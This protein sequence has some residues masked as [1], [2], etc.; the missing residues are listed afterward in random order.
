M[1]C[2]GAYAAQAIAL[3]LAPDR[4][5]PLNLEISTLRPAVDTPCRL[6]EVSTR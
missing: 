4:G 6:D 3:P 2:G 1:G 5:G